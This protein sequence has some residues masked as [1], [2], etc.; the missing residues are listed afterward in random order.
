M[1]HP[2]YLVVLPLWQTAA[3]LSVVVFLHTSDP[4]TPALIS[5]D[6]GPI[7]LVLQQSCNQS[8]KLALFPKREN[9]ICYTLGLYFAS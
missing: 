3:A 9:I 8:D 7:L 2:A 4:W 1:K 6:Q 5:S